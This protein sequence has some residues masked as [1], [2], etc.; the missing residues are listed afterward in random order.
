[1]VDTLAL[2]LMGVT[3][4]KSTV[5]AIYP[6]FVAFFFTEID[7]IVC[8]RG[9][10]SEIRASADPGRD[11]SLLARISIGVRKFVEGAGVTVWWWAS[12]S[13]PK[14]KKSGQLCGRVG[15]WG[16]HRKEA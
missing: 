7:I 14:S 4:S 15:R 12:L 9:A 1:M 10:T 6:S 3:H 13:V 16:G 5:R 11:I 8:Q 2:N